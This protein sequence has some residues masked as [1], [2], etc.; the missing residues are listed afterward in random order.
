MECKIILKK[1]EWWC[2]TCAVACPEAFR[3]CATCGISGPTAPLGIGPGVGGGESEPVW[4]HPS[5]DWECSHCSSACSTDHAYCWCCGGRKNPE[6]GLSS[7]AYIDF[8]VLFVVHCPFVLFC[9]CM[10]RCGLYT[11][12]PREPA[13]SGAVPLALSSSLPATFMVETILR[14]TA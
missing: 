9:N 13:G 1:G 10:L 5:G 3:F 11:A 2:F 8:L 6:V 14:L 4:I 7:F 12:S